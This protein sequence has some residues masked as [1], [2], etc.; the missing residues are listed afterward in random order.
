V[1]GSLLSPAQ[2]VHPVPAAERARPWHFSRRAGCLAAANHFDSSATRFARI[3]KTRWTP[4]ADNTMHSDGNVVGGSA[5]QVGG[6]P[7][8]CAKHP[9]NLGQSCHLARYSLECK[10]CP[11]NTVGLDG[12]ICSDCAAG[13]GPSADKTQC[14]PCA[15]GYY[16]QFGERC[17]ILTP[18]MWRSSEVESLELAVALGW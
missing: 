10:H 1:S 7:Y 2:R 18:F 5:V 11:E 14:L 8:D 9:C 16:S 15:D 4:F 6:V 13:E 3:L 12:I 17:L